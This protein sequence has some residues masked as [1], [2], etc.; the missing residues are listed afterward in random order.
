MTEDTGT[1]VGQNGKTAGAVWEVL[2]ENGPTTLNKLVDAVGGSRDTVI[3]KPSAGSPARRNLPS[4]SS[5]VRG[6]CVALRTFASCRGRENLR[7]FSRLWRR[8]AKVPPT[9]PAR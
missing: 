9:G 2:A 5:G 4:S 7:V 6:S 3:G 1:V 8:G